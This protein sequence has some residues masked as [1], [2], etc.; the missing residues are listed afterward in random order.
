MRE[1][2][3]SPEAVARP[4]A[5]SVLAAQELVA[6]R[7]ELP[8][9]AALHPVLVSR[10]SVLAGNRAVSGLLHSPSRTVQ[11]DGPAGGADT[12]APPKPAPRHTWVFIMGTDPPG[13]KN[14]FYTHAKA[15]YDGQYGA[16]ANSH[17]QTVSTLQEVMSTVNADGN[18]VG[19]LIVV[20]H[21][22][23]DGRMMF[24][25]GVTPDA[26][27]N[28]TLPVT[29][30]GGTPTQ[31]DTAKAAVSQGKLSTPGEKVIDAQTKIIIK[32]C[33]IGRSP[34]MVAVLKEAFGGRAGVTASTH[35]Q[36]FGGGQEH[37]AEYYV[38]KPGSVTLGPAALGKEFESKYGSHVPNMDSKAWAG[39]AKKVT[40]EADTVE[41]EAYRG[42]VPEATDAGFKAGFSAQIAELTQQG[43]TSILFIKR[44]VNG[45][46]YDYEYGAKKL[47]GGAAQAVTGTISVEIPPDDATAIKAAQDAS[48]RPD[49]YTFTAKRAKQGKETVVTV[50]SKRTEWKL[51]HVVI[52]DKSGAPIAPPAD[53]DAFWYTKEAATAPTA[54]TP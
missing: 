23:P 45:T 44:T 53:T 10:L 46:V 47:V 18:P 32:G 29:A 8:G 12:S 13:S 5:T 50:M 21:G 41:F 22:H 43:A 51:K 24:D 11:R 39:V 4:A 37:L 2:A 1:L 34:R 36:Q 26:P 35:A 14:P 49:A 28:T 30:A 6:A 33:N 3:E 17:V 9:A 15:Y 27:P 48:G 7:L 42:I 25:L 54:P 52:K 40:P 20:S 16:A 38:E 31:Y 19:L